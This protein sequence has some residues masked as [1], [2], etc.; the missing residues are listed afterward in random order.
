MVANPSLHTVWPALTVNTGG[1]FTV[2]MTALRGLEQTPCP[3]KIIFGR[4]LMVP[5]PV[6]VAQKTAGV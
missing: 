5:D 4:A 6:V 3:A 2:A 1:A